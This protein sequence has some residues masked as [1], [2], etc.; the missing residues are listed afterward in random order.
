MSAHDADWSR[1]RARFERCADATPEERERLLADLARS[2]PEVHARVLHLLALDAS[3]R[4]LASDVSDWRDHLILADDAGC[5]PERMGAWRVLREIGAGGMGRVFLAERADGAFEQKVALKLIRGEFTTAA[6]T[7]RFLVERGILARLQHPGIASLVDGGVDDDGRPWFAMQYVDGEPLPVYCREHASN[8]E[9]RLTLF[10]AVCEA[11]AYAHRQLVVHCD[12][13]PSN[14]LVDSEGLPRLLDFGIARLIAPDDGTAT[15]NTQTRLFTPGYAAPEQLAGEPVGVAADV[16]A[17]GAMLHELLSGRRP[18]AAVGESAA[19]LA[20]AHASGE[21]PPLSHAVNATAPTSSRRLRGDLDLIVATALRHDPVRR[22]PGADALADDLRRHLAGRPLRAQRDS[23]SHRVRKFIA[24]HRVAV[25]LAAG[26]LTALVATT[27]FALI[28][29]R[30]AHLQ[31]ERAEATRN[32]LLDLFEQ[33]DPDRKGEKALSARDLIDLGARRVQHDLGSAPDTRIDLQGVVGNLYESLGESAAA[34]DIRAKRLAEAENRYPANDPRIAQARIDL[35]RSEGEREH[36]DQ[37]RAYAR[38]AIDALPENVASHRKLRASALGALG[39]IERRAGRFEAAAEAQTRRISL[40]RSLAPEATADLAEALD[41][42]GVVEHAQGRYDASASSYREAL[43]IIEA[44]ANAKP[45]VL[46]RIR[47][48]LALAEHERAHFEE[49]ER[50]FKENLALARQTYGDNHRTVADQL[51]QLGQNLRQS[52][53]EQES[54]P[55]LQQALALYE[56][57]NGPTHSRVATALTTL[58]Q[59][60][61]RTGAQPEAIANL[62]RAYRIYLDSLGPRHL[63]TAVGET[64]LAQAK[65]EAGDAAG[66]E[67]V[68]RDTLAKYADANPQHIF[69]EAARRGLGEALTAQGRLA[70]AEPLLR[71]VQ[72]RLVAKFGEA[73]HRSESAAIALATCLHAAGRT[74]EATAVLSATRSAIERAA[75]TPTRSRNLEKLKTAEETLRRP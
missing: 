44:Q 5:V 46:I 27:A 33:A 70:D 2:E 56:R 1:L 64:A 40:L 74:T 21:A 65:L 58:A 69:A 43:E 32:F 13:K 11:V 48:D 72:Q 52:G 42:L 19:A 23:T 28:Q 30:D 39:G 54:L 29:S 62:E 25:P 22:Y 8:V 14:V 53:R 41:D 37:A 24:R 34:S 26:A 12:L 38:A 45:S 71:T 6:A 18:Y 47:Y 16:Y 49:A 20:V 15:S 68:F 17:L 66:A 57:I 59:A 73:D 9:D 50:L 60:Q 3:E 67:T 61:L 55:W 4:D 51:Y 7:A 10:I 35:A 75:D 63:Y 31:A 36:F